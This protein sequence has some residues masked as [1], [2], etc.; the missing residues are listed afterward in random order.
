MFYFQQEVNRDAIG[1]PIAL[2]ILISFCI[3]L[4]VALVYK[5]MQNRKEE[6]VIKQ[7]MLGYVFMES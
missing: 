6:K 2:G 3:G 7:E 4:I 5:V 1:S